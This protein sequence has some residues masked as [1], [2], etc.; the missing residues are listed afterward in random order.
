MILEDY[1]NNIN[2]SEPGIIINYKNDV[3]WSNKSCIIFSSKR[4][5]NIDD[6]LYLNYDQQIS[7]KYSI[8]LMNLYSYNENTIIFIYYYRTYYSCFSGSISIFFNQYKNY[9]NKYKNIIFDD[10][11]NMQELLNLNIKTI[12]FII[13]KI[14]KEI[15][16]GNQTIFIIDIVNWSIILKINLTQ[17]S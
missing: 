3:A 17:K 15:V 2:I 5:F 10:F 7:E 16:F 6:S 11:N 13:I 8:H 14:I 4:K 12:K 1:L 9:E